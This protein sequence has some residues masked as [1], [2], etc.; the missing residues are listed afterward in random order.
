VR[1]F[2]T[3]VLVAAGLVVCGGVAWATWGVA[4][5]GDGWSRATVMPAGERPTASVAGRNVTVSWNASELTGGTPVNG[6]R[7]LRYDGGSVAQSVGSSCSGTINA[8]TCVEAAVPPGTWTYAIVPKQFAWLGA[9]GAESTSVNVAAPSFSFS[10]PTTLTSLPRTLAGSLQGY[11]TGESVVFRLDDA[12]TGT[13]LAGSIAPDP[14]PSSGAASAIVTIAAGTL[15]GAH[16]VYAVG[17]A[18]STASASI[19]VGDVVAPTVSSAVI[20]K[21]AGGTAGFVEQGG[22]YYVYANVTDPAPGSGVATVTANVSTITTGQTAVVLSGGVFTVDGVSYNYRS[23]S[24]TATNPLAAGSKVFSVTATDASAN[25]VTQGGFAVTVDNTAPV[26]VD[27]QTANNG[28]TVGKAET[29]DTAA[30][31]FSEPIDPATILSGWTGSSTTVTVRLVNNGGG[32]RV[33][34]WNAANTTKLPF[35]TVNLGSAGFVSSTVTF[36]ASTMV[37]SGS[38]ITVTFGTPGGTTLTAAAPGS[39]LW[40]PSSTPTDRA[41]NACSTAVVT[42]SGVLDREF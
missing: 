9:E 13:V 25:S 24:R 37:L 14:V 6:Y 2:A 32:D 30:F 23:A 4:G 41:G 38:T 39:I 27:V 8:L 36:S 29:G 40:T 35:G 21:T 11:V 42:E 1:R 22:A 33:Q 3:V 10:L 18:G 15:V 5:T 31:T 20:A 19:T 16:T 17:S 12:S 28:S 34:V 26:A 7:V